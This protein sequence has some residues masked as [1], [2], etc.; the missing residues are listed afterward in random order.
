[1]RELI[2]KSEVEEQIQNRKRKH[3]AERSGSLQ[4]LRSE[5]SGTEIE[6]ERSQKKLKKVSQFRQGQAIAMEYDDSEKK[7][8]SK[9][10]QKIFHR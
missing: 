9:L 2:E 4:T 3:Q 8:S 10:L 7:I 5:G 1:M 6:G